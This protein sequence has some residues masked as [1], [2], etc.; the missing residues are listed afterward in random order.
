MTIP[1]EVDPSLHT[2]PHEATLEDGFS[3]PEIDRDHA[4]V[5]AKPAQEPVLSDKS[6]F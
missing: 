4:E 3:H 1:Y 5:P 6:A 2:E